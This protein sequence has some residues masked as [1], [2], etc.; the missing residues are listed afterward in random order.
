MKYCFGIDVGGTAIKLGL[1]E[2]SGKLL[3]HWSIPT[4]IG[5][6]AALIYDDAAAAVTEKM[7]EKGIEKKDLIGVGVDMPGPVYADGHMGK[8]SN[9]FAAGGYP[10]EEISRRLD[11]VKSA[12]TNDANAAA[13]GEMWMGAGKG[14]SS[15]CMATLGTGVGGG[16]IHD[17]QIIAGYHGAA[18]EL[19]HVQIQPEETEYCNCGGRGCCEFY[20]SA[21]GIVRV[22]KRILQSGDP[23]VPYVEGKPLKYADSEMAGF[24]D[25]LST[26]DICILAAEGDELANQVLD[27]SMEMLGK[28][29]SYVTYVTDPE[30]FVIGGGVSEAGDI[31]LKRIEKAIVKYSTLLK[32][33]SRNVIPAKLGNK[34]G[35]YGAAALV[36]FNNY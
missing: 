25:T 30:V 21:T 36:L 2:E 14:Y 9:I 5:E 4:R 17:G 1:F 6:N 31:V 23:L 8:A 15:L 29:M 3:D 35:I 12:V 10:A 34:A 32:E 13:F 24:G 11:G 7:A 26:R 18:G 27:F 33:Q 22:A 16:I 28:A 20:A 19:G